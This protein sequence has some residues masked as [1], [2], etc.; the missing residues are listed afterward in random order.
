MQSQR[1]IA[2][3]GS[4]LVIVIV[5]LFPDMVLIARYLFVHRNRLESNTEHWNALLLSLRELIEWVIRKD[6]ELTGLGP[7][8]GD[9]ATLQKQQVS[10]SKSFPSVS[11]IQQIQ[12]PTS[13]R[14]T[15]VFSKRCLNPFGGCGASQK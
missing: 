7:V 2:F 6:T 11:T 12:A 4:F 10:L 1:E 14:S 5:F 9:A 8:C 15:L 13:R 3:F